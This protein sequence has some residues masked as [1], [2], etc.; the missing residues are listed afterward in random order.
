MERKVFLKLCS[1]ILLEMGFRKNGTTHFY[2]DLSEDIM[3]VVALSHSKYDAVYWFD[4]GFVIKPINK[5]MP[6]PKFYD[7]NIRTMHIAI[8]KK[9]SIDY[10]NITQEELSMLE[11][12]MEK[13]LGFY[14]ICCDRSTLMEKIILP[15]LY[16]YGKDY[17]IQ[18]YLNYSFPPRKII[19]DE[20]QIN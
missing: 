11:T 20:S 19:P 3:L 18:E 10:L 6:N 2:K 17:D 1:K 8:G 14:L 5:H 7:A 16:A 4:G 9:G 15:D 12:S 13:T